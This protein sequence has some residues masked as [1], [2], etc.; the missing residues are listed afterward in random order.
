MFN[1]FEN[2]WKVL[3]LFWECFG[4]FLEHFWKFLGKFGE[5]FRK[6][7]GHFWDDLEKLFGKIDQI[8]FTN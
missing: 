1:V 3:G 8:F 6:F 4:T 7:W 5:T 2:F